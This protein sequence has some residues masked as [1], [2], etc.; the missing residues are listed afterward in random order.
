MGLTQ[1]CKQ[2][3]E[4]KKIHASAFDL[5]DEDGDAKVNK[6]EFDFIADFIHKQHVLDSAEAHKRLAQCK[7]E[8]YLYEILGKNKNCKLKRKDFN[9][10]AYSVPVRV[11]K[12]QIIPALRNKEIA[13]LSR[14]QQNCYR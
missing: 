14:E 2:A 13:R 12:T 10:L 5:I 8:D 3:K 9:K 6:A 4:R 7:P 1:S 11:W